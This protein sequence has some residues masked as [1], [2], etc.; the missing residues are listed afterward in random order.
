MTVPDPVSQL[1]GIL[2]PKSVAVIGASTSPDKLGHEILKNILDGGYQGA[3]YPINPK[4]D[5]ILNL[6]CH[7]NVKEL[8]EPPDLAVLIIPAALPKLAPRARNCS[9]KQLK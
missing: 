5:T 6:P 9:S 8:E 3:V 1:A 2:R 7:T 4:A